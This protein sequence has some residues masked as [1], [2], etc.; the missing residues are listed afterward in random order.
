MSKQDLLLPVGSHPPALP[1]PHFPDR[2]HTFVW[3]NWQLAEVDRL[4]EVV[5]TTPENITQLASSMGLPANVS[6]DPM[7]LKR[8]Y[9]TILRRNWHLLP[10]DQILQ[11]LGITT[12]QLEFSLHEDD[13]L[14]IKLGSLKPQCEPLHYHKPDAKAQ[15]RAAGIKQL[16]THYFDDQLSQDGEQ[17]FEFL[18]QLTKLDQQ[19]SNRDWKTNQTQQGLRFICSYFGNFGDPLSDGTADPC[20]DGL[21]AK[22]ASVGVNGVWMHVVLR[23]LAPGGKHF[24]EFGAGHQQRLENLRKLV[25]KTK[26]FGIGIYL[27]L[28]EPR[29]MPPEFFAERPEMAGVKSRDL[30]TMCTSDS[31]VRE[32]L[33]AS[34]EY[35]FREVPDLAGVFTITASENPTNCA[36]AAGQAECPHCRERSQAEIVAEVNKSIVTGVHRGNPDARVLVYDW[37]WNH[38]G[39]ATDTIAQL[40]SRVELLSVSEW[41]LPIERGGV[42]GKVGEYSISAVGPGPRARRHWKLAQQRGLKTVAKVQLNNSWELAALPFLPV[43][44]L[45]AEH[46]ENLTAVDIDGMMLSWSL[47][48]YP[49]PN[50][51]V[52]HLFDTLPNANQ[53]TVLNTIARQRYGVQAMP[54]V[55]NAWTAFSDA[56]REFPYNANVLYFAP[57]QM[58]PANLLYGEPTGYRATMVGIPYDSMDTWRGS[59]SA[60]VLAQQFEKMATQWQAGLNHFE[61]VVKATSDEQHSVALADF[62]LARAA[63]LHFASTANQIRFVLTRDLLRETDLEANKEQELRK[64]LHQLLDHEIQLA[65]EYFTLVQQDSRIGFEASNHYFYVPLDLIEKVINCDFLKRKSLES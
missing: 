56:F 37:G 18:E 53:D 14:Y 11:L 42:Q 48:G 60:E 22:L 59:F 1:T 9:I 31:R 44:D 55:R 27:Y 63:Q 51:Q 52:A 34:L 50:L 24:P 49:S 29:A 2:L 3:R 15:A 65:R 58:G 30:V 25:A 21:L 26:K 16:V 19:D 23:Q 35:L 5:G 17:R 12:N 13:F 8:A 28:N 6:T 40:P 10:Y 43:L 4:A 7:L 46:C 36:Y 20:P 64:Q 33:S 41:A 47:G 57:H 45:V 39:D 62:G 61:R 32:W 38:H 54:D